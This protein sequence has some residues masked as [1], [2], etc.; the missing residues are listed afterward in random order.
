MPEKKSGGANLALS[1]LIVVAVLLL[2]FLVPL[3][4]AF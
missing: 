2:L 1:T 3:I 4:I